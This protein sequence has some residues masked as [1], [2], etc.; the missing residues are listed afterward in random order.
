MNNDEINRYEAEAVR[1]AVHW[2][3]TGLGYFTMEEKV[4]D[5]IA[6]TGA[7]S[8]IGGDEAAILHGRRAATLRINIMSISELSKAEEQKL[9]D[10]L[11]EIAEEGAMQQRNGMHR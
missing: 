9:H 8:S 4:N 1:Y 3:K 6:A 10:R 11:I 2:A 7:N 5:Y